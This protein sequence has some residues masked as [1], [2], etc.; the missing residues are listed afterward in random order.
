MKWNISGALSKRGIYSCIICRPS[1]WKGKQSSFWKR[2]W[3]VYNVHGSYDNEG[4]GTYPRLTQLLHP[5]VY[6]WART[7]T[8][9]VG[10]CFMPQPLSLPLSSL[11]LSTST[12]LPSNTPPPPP[13]PTHTQN[14]AFLPFVWTNSVVSYFLQINIFFN[15]GSNVTMLLL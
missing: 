12:L 1:V 3:K 5:N 4:N 9:L 14:P 13:H 6:I 7:R 15:H 8:R 10:Y 11:S 2:T